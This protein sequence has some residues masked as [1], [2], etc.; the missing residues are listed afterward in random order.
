M[1]KLITLV[2]IASA[3]IG[4]NAQEGTAVVLL[5]PNTVKKKVEKSN[6]EIQDSK[7]SAKAGTW[8]KRGELYQDAFNIGIEQTSEGMDSKML[9][10]FYKEPKSIET[11]NMDNGSVKE[12]YLYDNMKYVFVN[13]ALESWVKINPIHEDPLRVAIDSYVKALE[14]DTKG[15]LAAKIKDN[16]IEVKDLLKRDGVNNYY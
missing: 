11:E 12:T 2:I 4:M 5:N 9:T 8:Q 7:K 3:V 14:L 15:S 6:E 1:R 16:L 10:L 13:D